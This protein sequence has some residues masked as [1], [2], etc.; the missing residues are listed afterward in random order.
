MTTNTHFTVILGA[1]QRKEGIVKNVGDLGRMSK[2]SDNKPKTRRSSSYDNKERFVFDLEILEIH[3]KCK[4]RIKA[5]IPYYNNRHTNYRKTRK[6]IQ[7]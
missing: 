4:N 1:T 2:T 5:T 3:E 6:L 7:I